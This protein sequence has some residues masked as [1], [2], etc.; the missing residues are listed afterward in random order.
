MKVLTKLIRLE[1]DVRAIVWDYID[2]KL[3]NLDNLTDNEII[4]L[5]NIIVHNKL[6]NHILDDLIRRLKE[7]KISK[8]PMF[9]WRTEMQEQERINLIRALSTIEKDK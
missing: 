5:A 7:I 1:N 6:Y 4:T 9:E 8:D 2:E 3:H